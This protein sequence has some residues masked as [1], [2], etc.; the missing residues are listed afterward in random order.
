VETYDSHARIQRIAADRLMELISLWNHTTPNGPVLEIGCGT[1]LLTEKLLDFFQD[2]SIL[3]SDASKEMLAHCEQKIKRLRKAER[4]QLANL[5]A[6][7][8]ARQFEKSETYSVIASAFSLQWLQDLEEVIESLLNSLKAGGYLAFCVPSGNSFPEWRQ[9]C[10]N[11]A[12]PFTGNSLPNLQFFKAL[13]DK[14]GQPF[15]FVTEDTTITYNSPTSFF[16]SLK[17]TGASISLTG[18]K[19]SYA[20]MRRLLSEWPRKEGKITVT[21]EIIYGQMIRIK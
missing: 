1:G 21:Y 7:K 19:L 13:N 14:F 16:N 8:F 5:D 10:E 9:A 17:A 4:L 18:R 11:A 6:T 20:Q 12:V 3:A 2:K 15:R